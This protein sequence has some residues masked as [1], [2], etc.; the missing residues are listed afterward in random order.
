METAWGVV[1]RN[2]N[3]FTQNTRLLGQ[4]VRDLQKKGN[5]L[6]SIFENNNIT[7]IIVISFPREMS[8]LYTF[9]SEGK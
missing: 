3:Y 8:K 9:K 2:F 6:I 1:S 7:L 4:Q 5:L